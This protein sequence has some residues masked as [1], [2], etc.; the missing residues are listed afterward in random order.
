MKL[1]KNSIASAL[2]TGTEIVDYKGNVLNYEG[3]QK[4]D[5]FGFLGGTRNPTLGPHRKISD[6]KF[7]VLDAYFHLINEPLWTE[8]NGSTLNIEN[9]LAKF[10]RPDAIP[11]KNFFKHSLNEI[12]ISKGSDLR[13]G[14]KETAESYKIYPK[15][16]A[17]L[18][19]FNMESS[20][21]FQIK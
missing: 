18:R 2:E 11:S 8:F 3:L 4:D 19:V 15:R 9:A 5:L 14:L 7:A 16:I 17:A 10:W 1:V 13:K 21:L 12:W 6:A 20:S